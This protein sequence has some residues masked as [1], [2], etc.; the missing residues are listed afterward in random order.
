MAIMLLGTMR[1]VGATGGRPRDPL[2]SGQRAG[3]RGNILPH[4]WLPAMVALLPHR[5]TAG[6]P[7]RWHPCD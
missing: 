5:A 7:Y 3:W 4:A 2:Y 1:T 6:R